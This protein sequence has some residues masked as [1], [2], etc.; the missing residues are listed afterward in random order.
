MFDFLSLPFLSMLGFSIDK[1]HKTAK[2]VSSG[3]D[4]LV[5]N[6]S[7]TLT[8]AYVPRSRLLMLQ[9][10]GLHSTKQSK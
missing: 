2:L 1:H 6:I 9:G 7:I 3:R 8:N 10:I 4:G 5:A